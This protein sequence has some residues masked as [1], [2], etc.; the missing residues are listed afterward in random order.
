M[1]KRRSNRI[2]LG[3]PA[4]GRNRTTLS[5]FVPKG[6]LPFSRFCK[7]PVDAGKRRQSGY[8]VNEGAF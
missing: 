1:R 7:M 6:A 8:Y 3:I 2:K 5:Q 4:Q